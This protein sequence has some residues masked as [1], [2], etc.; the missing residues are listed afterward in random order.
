[1]RQSGDRLRH[2]VRKF[3]LWLGLSFGALLVLLGLTGSVLAFYP[4]LDAMLHPEIRVEGE[5][6][7]DFDRA[8]ATLRAEWPDKVGGWRF[9]VTGTNGAIPARYY[10]P[11]E[12][13][14]YSFRPLM[15]WLSPD[16][17]TVLRRDY[18]GEYAVTFVYDVHNK[19]LLDSIGG[20]LV[21]WLGFGCLALLLT[22]LWAWWPRGAMSGQS[23]AKALRFKRNA[24]PQR[25][26][27]DWHKLVGLSGLVFLLLLTV[28]GIMLAL[29]EESDTAL[30]AAGLTVSAAPHIHDTGATRPL[31]TSPSQAV[32]AAQT[33]L[34]GA[35]IAWIETPPA[36]G[37]NWR[38]RMQVAGDPSFRF[39]HSFV[40][41]DGGSG[42]VV[43]VQD[44]RV[45][46]AG[47]VVN[48][49]LHPLHDGSA[50]GLFGRILA[51]LAGLVPALLFW[52]GWLRWRRS[53]V[54]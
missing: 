18:W 24:H 1:M 39:P 31:R 32:A 47:T 43:A 9:E 10:K 5:A 44:A 19:L 36:Q 15:V 49:W 48:N 35:R 40:W 13:P 6:S 37:G 54:T 34:P 41:V 16:G 23:W 53:K 3:H 21:G 33:A 20:A 28:T 46:G 2:W 42:R 50:G 8:L 29:P 30:G 25:R 4:E 45:G 26:L 11:L 17:T 14:G 12:R 52:T 22:G 38:I 51:V 7:P 27:R